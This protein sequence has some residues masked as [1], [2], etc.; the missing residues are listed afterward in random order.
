[1]DITILTENPVFQKMEPQKQ[2]LLLDCAK[3]SEGVPFDKTLPMLVSMNQRMKALGIS[4]TAEEREVMID[5]LTVHLSSAERSKLEMLK[6]M[7]R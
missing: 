3:Q 4:F 2:K 6:K 5:S 7:I 1:M